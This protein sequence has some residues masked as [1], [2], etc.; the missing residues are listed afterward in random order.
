MDRNIFSEWNAM[1]NDVFFSFTAIAIIS[2]FILSSSHYATWITFSVNVYAKDLDYN[3][4]MA[5]L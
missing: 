4:K 3:L 2:I 5:Q 1:N